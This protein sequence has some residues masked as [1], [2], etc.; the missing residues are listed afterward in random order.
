MEVISPALSSPPERLDSQVITIMAQLTFW[1]IYPCVHNIQYMY[2][3]IYLSIYEV[4]IVY[5]HVYL[6]SVSLLYMTNVG[7]L[8]ITYIY[9]LLYQISYA[10]SEITEA[11]DDNDYNDY[12]DVS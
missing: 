7:F 3:I 6:Y 11:S 9:V 4:T 12:Y 1:G 2:C 10:D 8:I 5:I